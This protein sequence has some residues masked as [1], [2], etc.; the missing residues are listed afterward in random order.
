MNRALLSI[1][2][3]LT[4]FAVF[5]QT[6]KLGEANQTE[7]YLGEVPFEP[8]APAVILMTQGESKFFGNVFETTYFVRLKI[9]TEVGKQYADVRIR[10]YVGDKRYEEI[11][12]VKAQTVNYVR[13]AK[14]EEI[15]VEKEGIFDVAVNNGYHEVRISFPNVQ[16]GSILEYTYK[17][18]DK[19]ITFIDGWAFQNNIPTLFSK[20]QITMSPYLGYRTIGQGSNYANKVEKTDS[21][22]T[23]S[24]TLRDQYSLKEEPFMKNYRDYVDRIEFQLTQYQTRSSTA[25]VEWEKVLN[26]WEALGDDMISYYS[27]KGFYRSNPIEKETLNTDLSGSSQK[28]IAGKAYYYLRNNYLIEGEDWIYPKQ[29]LNQ[30]LKSK[31]GTPVEMML[32]L[33]GIL[34]SVGIKCDPVLIGSKGYG[35][36]ELVEYP[37][38]T[39]FDEILLLTE[40]D[41]SLQ[42]LDLS[43]RM[44]PFGYV[45]LDKHVSGGLYLQKKESKLI[46]ISI[47]HNSN[48]VHFSQVRLNE[49]GQLWMQSSYRNYFYKGLD[50]AHLVDYKNKKSEPLDKLFKG[51]DDIEFRNFKV[52]DA[53]HEK[54]YYT[55]SYELTFPES[56]N[57]EMISFRPLKFSTFSENPFPEEYRV[58]PVDFEYPF[59]ETYN[60]NV[61]IPTGY[62]IDD[63]PL[64]E[65]F[66]IDGGYVTFMYSPTMMDNMLK[67]T[68]RFEVKIP[69]IPAYQYGNLK[70]FMES[71]ASKLSEPVILKKKSNP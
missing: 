43:D 34:K 36:S 33:M 71:V 56:E 60:S 25:G 47:R 17:K 16:V 58:F 23:Y 37:F 31:V 70:Y 42:F 9:L 27:D 14:T 21:N 13:G 59:A 29:T 38:L 69:L 4:S 63:Y 20:Y 54:N 61:L 48:T 44:A 64:Q 1:S 46:P 32:A 30:L 5:S 35:R 51:E 57:A 6:A 3:F 28:E 50:L 24:W 7:I 53:L 10:Y 22:G 62:E 19:N 68:A 15:K 52:D 65:S 45:D 18:T 2:L 11:S 67:I 26:T 40:L 66:T 39:Q 49:S 8:D 41:G 55:L 12:G